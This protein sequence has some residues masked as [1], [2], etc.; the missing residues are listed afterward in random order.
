MATS[1]PL[2]NNKPAQYMSPRFY[3][4]DWSWYDVFSL[5]SFR[6]LYKIVNIWSE[7]IFSILLKTSSVRNLYFV[8][9][10]Q[11]AGNNKQY[12][13][14]YLLNYLLYFIDK[15]PRDHWLWWVKGLTG[16][17]LLIPVILTK[18]MS[19]IIQLFS[20]SFQRKAAIIKMVNLNVNNF[21]STRER[22]RYLNN[23]IFYFYMSCSYWVFDLGIHIST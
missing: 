15:F 19:I 14:K 2:S 9:F 6:C 21:D 12:E 8:R 5:V 17:K 23:K 16:T 18:N 13:M 4:M 11:L 22:W 1:T 3:H 7:C 20:S 10:P